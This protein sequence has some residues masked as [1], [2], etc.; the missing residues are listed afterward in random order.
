MKCIDLEFLNKR[1]KS[2]PKLMMEMIS[3][4]LEQTPQLVSTM[5]KGFHDKDWNSLYS[6]VHK[7]IPSFLPM[8]ISI[9]FEI[10]ARK[11]RD[12]ANTQRQTKGLQGMVIQLE[13][14][15]CQ[16]CIEL[17]QELDTIKKKTNVWTGVPK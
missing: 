1:T 14:I 16:A 10:M 6:A 9:E 5:K 17:E 3:L 13:H 7:M 8:G 4:Y 2:N 11:V 12:Y 15:C